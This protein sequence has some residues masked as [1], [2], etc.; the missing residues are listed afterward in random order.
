M[1]LNKLNTLEQSEINKI[2]YNK[3]ITSNGFR[4]L[5]EQLPFAESFSLGITI[6]TGSR[7]D[8]EGLQGLAHMIEHCVFR[9]SKNRSGKQIAYQFESIGA[10]T[11]AFTT[12]E[13]TCFYVRAL[14]GNFEKCLELLV[15]LVFNPVFDEKDVEKEKKIIIEEIKSYEDDPEEMICDYAD[16]IL[17]GDIPLGEPIAGSISSVK[18]A[19]ADDLK[20]Y[21]NEFY[22]PENIVISFAGNFEHEYLVDKIGDQIKEFQ[23]EKFNSI[24]NNTFIYQK[25]NIEEVKSFQQT[26]ILLANKIPGYNTALRYPMAALNVI[27]G[28][29]MSSRLYQQLREKNSLAYTIYSSLT[30]YTDTGSISIYS[31]TDTKKIKK[32]EKLIIEELNKLIEKKILGTELDR[33]KEQLKSSTIMAME[34]MSTRMQSLAKSELLLGEN[35]DIETTIDLINGVTLDQIKD[36]AEKYYNF[37]QWSKIVFLPE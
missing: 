17:F 16:K 34:S 9:Q 6:N 29:G 25:N 3:T 21:H 33:A 14:S 19:K 20:K 32:V 24:R 28:E 1:K 2:K 5:T 13:V 15:D 27:L 11:N 31:A 23:N 18:K 10:Y 36:V 35:E 8:Y 30:Q 4:I 12:K 26:H 37:D 22:K 7:D